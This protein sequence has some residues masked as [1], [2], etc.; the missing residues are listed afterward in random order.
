MWKSGTSS[1]NIFFGVLAQR[2]VGTMANR[3]SHI[4]CTSANLKAL[5]KIPHPTWIRGWKWTSCSQWITVQHIIFLHWLLLLTF[6]CGSDSPHALT[7]T[8]SSFSPSAGI[9]AWNRHTTIWNYGSNHQF[10]CSCSVA[11]L[12][13]SVNPPVIT[14]KARGMFTNNLSLGCAVGK[15]VHSHPTHFMAVCLE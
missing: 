7:S 15:L 1:E 2:N 14:C 6:E 8:S 3:H 10:I 12:N 5:K 13:V 9:S 4:S 11:V